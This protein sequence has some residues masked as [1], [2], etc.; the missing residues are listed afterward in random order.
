MI[1]V[2][3]R[4]ER[5]D[6]FNV[7]VDKMQVTHSHV[8]HKSHVLCSLGLVVVDCL[9][10]GGRGASHISR[11]CGADC[12]TCLQA[13]RS[14]RAVGPWKSQSTNAYRSTCMC[15]EGTRSLQVAMEIAMGQGPRDLE[16]LL[17]FCLASMKEATAKVAAK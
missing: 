13:S 15:A 11:F 4:P 6:L 12:A 5:L 17:V 3:F 8:K 14:T 16:E 1:V 9:G 2:S 10:G 7:A